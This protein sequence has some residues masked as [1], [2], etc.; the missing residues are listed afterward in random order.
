[1]QCHFHV[2]VQLTEG[3]KQKLKRKQ[4]LKKNLSSTSSRNIYPKAMTIRNVEKQ[5]IGNKD[6]KL[7]IYKIY[8]LALNSSDDKK[9]YKRYWIT[10][11]DMQKLVS[12]F[13]DNCIFIFLDKC[14]F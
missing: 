2:F 11:S 10:S 5:R 7:Y 13:I 3:K 9:S 8:K 1:M 12:N 14:I 6:H 4:F